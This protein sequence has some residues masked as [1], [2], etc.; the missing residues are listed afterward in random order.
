[1]A[2]FPLNIAQGEFV[3]IYGAN[4]ANATQQAT[5]STYPTQL[6]D[7]QVLVNGVAVP[8]EYVSA[9]QI[10]A[11]FSTTNTSGV[12]QLTLQNSGGS[13]TINVLLAP[14]VPEIFSL[15]FTGAGAAAAING[16][17]GAVVGASNPLHAGDY[18]SLFLTGLGAT[19]AQN[20]LQYA[21]TQPAIT[22][23]SQ[24]CRV[25]YAGRAPT[26]PGVDQINC[27]V[28]SGVSGSALPVIVTSG[29]RASNTVTLAVQ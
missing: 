18:L 20:G 14:A 27:V 9:S 11:V 21:Q 19:T 26:I 29:G 25:T 12:V 4:L 16:V 10:N 24:S 5:S 15:D 3:A 6:A 23:G 13:T 17:T 28:P 1:A 7:A 8:L 2:A 22:I